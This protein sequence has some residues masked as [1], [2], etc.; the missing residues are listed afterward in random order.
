ML[1]ALAYTACTVEPS[2]AIVVR[3]NTQEV[4]LDFPVS[5]VLAMSFPVC[6]HS[7]LLLPLLYF[8]GPLSGTGFLCWFSNC[9]KYIYWHIVGIASCFFLV[10]RCILCSPLS[11]LTAARF[12]RGKTT[13]LLWM[14]VLVIHCPNL[15]RTR[16]MTSSR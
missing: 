4:R 6:L 15:P 2:C 7:F 5:H 1:P 13:V 16:I 12:L 3:I 8:E 14:T 9:L 10:V 11:L